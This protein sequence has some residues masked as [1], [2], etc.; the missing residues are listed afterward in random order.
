MKFQSD[1]MQAAHNLDVSLSIF[2]AITG[3]VHSLEGRIVHQHEIDG[4]SFPLTWCELSKGG[5]CRVQSIVQLFHG[6]N[7]SMQIT[8]ANHEVEIEGGS[9]I[10]PHIDS[11][12]ADQDEIQIRLPSLVRET[13]INIE[14]VH[15]F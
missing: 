4:N 7:P 10:T 13:L 12:T 6:R 8:A 5:L 3:R 1:Q 11:M 9:Y 14:G 15:R 2:A